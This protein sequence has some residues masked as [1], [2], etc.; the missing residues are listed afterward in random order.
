M[1]TLNQG[2]ENIVVAALIAGFWSGMLMDKLAAYTLR[3][4]LPVLHQVAQW[5]PALLIVAGLIVLVRH[6]QTA[7]KPFVPARRVVVM[8]PRKERAHAR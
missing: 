1:S 7:H 5:W 8:Q 3:W 2:A 4:N 6:K